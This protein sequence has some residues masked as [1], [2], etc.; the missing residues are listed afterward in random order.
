M[1]LY[2]NLLTGFISQS[3]LKDYFFSISLV[4]YRNYLSSSASVNHSLENPQG[5]KGVIFLYSTTFFMHFSLFC[6]LLLYIFFVHTVCMLTVKEL[7]VKRRKNTKTTTFSLFPNWT[8]F[9]VKVKWFVRS[10]RFKG[11][12]FEK[13]VGQKCCIT[14]CCNF[15]VCFH[16][17]SMLYSARGLTFLYRLCHNPNTTISD[18]LL[19]GKLASGPLLIRWQNIFVVKMVYLKWCTHK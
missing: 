12:E 16:H 8:T 13:R 19:P 15:F 17:A 4:K 2:D 5:G 7:F 1:D 3:E 9:T 18:R 10:S 11:T 6:F 14:E